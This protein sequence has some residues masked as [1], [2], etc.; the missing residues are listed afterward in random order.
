MNSTTKDGDL[1]VKTP[2]ATVVLAYGAWRDGAGLGRQEQLSDANAACG[3]WQTTG[4][5]AAA[6]LGGG[7][8]GLPLRRRAVRKMRWA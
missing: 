8:Q 6:H 7:K 3:W 4:C 5:P 1:A 2:H